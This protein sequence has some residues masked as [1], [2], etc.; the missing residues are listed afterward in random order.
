ML[1]DVYFDSIKNCVRIS[2]E[3]DDGKENGVQNVGCSVESIAKRIM[4]VH[5]SFKKRPASL[6]FSRSFSDCFVND[7]LHKLKLYK[8]RGQSNSVK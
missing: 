3:T 4:D 1:I 5:A 6:Y 2:Y 7:V 8:S